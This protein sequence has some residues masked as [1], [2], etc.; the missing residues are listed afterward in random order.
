MRASIAT[1]GWLLFAF[2]Y[3]SG[4]AE[5]EV[6]VEES[7]TEVEATGKQDELVEPLPT[8][9]SQDASVTSPQPG[10]ATSPHFDEAVRTAIMASEATQTAETA[11]QWGEVADLWQQAIESMKAV[12]ETDANYQTAQTK[13]GKYEANLSY[14][15]E[16]VSNIRQAQ[17][18]LG[19]EILH[20][21]NGVFQLW[22]EGAELPVVS[23]VF[24]QAIWGNLSTEEKKALALYTSSRIPEVRQSPGKFMRIPSTAP[25]Y[26]RIVDSVSNLCD[27]CWVIIIGERSS[28]GVLQIDKVVLQGDTPWEHDDPCCR[29]TK[30]S[31]FG[32]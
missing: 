18:N 6:L 31:D 22:G 23:T 9:S 29:G 27:D 15:S 28:N 19:Q 20:K 1:A 26:P 32:I 13:A 4:P 30:A 5:Q 8:G 12:P 11:Q 21:H 10:K 25:I 2:I 7:S 24:D 16:N 14:A 3:N 17:I